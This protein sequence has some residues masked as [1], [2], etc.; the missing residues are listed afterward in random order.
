MCRN[1]Q[2][3]RVYLHCMY[4]LVYYK[5]RGS[6]S[7][8]WLFATIPCDNN[9]IDAAL[10]SLWRIEI[11]LLIYW[12]YPIATFYNKT[13]WNIIP[14]KGIS[15]I[16]SSLSLVPLP[17]RLLSTLD[18]EPQTLRTTN[19]MSNCGLWATATQKQQQRTNAQSHLLL[20]CCR[21]LLSPWGSGTIEYH[22]MMV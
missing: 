1:L 21:P 4:G 7:S 18:P 13:L 20:T 14:I 22:L 16:S 19:R 3:L 2:I 5:I 9:N 8:F 15:P 6:K 12:W 11:P 17:S 10:S